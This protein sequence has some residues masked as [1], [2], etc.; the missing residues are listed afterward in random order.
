EDKLALL[1]RLIYQRKPT[2]ME[3]RLA[4]NYIHNESSSSSSDAGQ[5]G[6]S[7][8]EYG[9][10]HFDPATKRVKDFNRMTVFDG[11]AWQLPLDPRKPKLG[12]IRLNADGG[13][14]SEGISA[15]RRWTAPRDGVIS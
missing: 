1:Y 7:A 2:D 9:Y 12:T 8:W 6:E 13:L 11:K 14:T 3:M 10:G 4:M 5:I 15:V